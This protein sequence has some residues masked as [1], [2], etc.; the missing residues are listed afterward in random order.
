MQVHQ[1]RN[2]RLMIKEKPLGYMGF[3]LT[4]SQYIYGF[5]KS[6][7]FPTFCSL[8]PW[9]VMTFSG[10]PYGGAVKQPRQRWAREEHGNTAEKW[11]HLWTQN[12]R[13]ESTMDFTGFTSRMESLTNHLQH[14]ATLPSNIHKCIVHICRHST[15]TNKLHTIYTK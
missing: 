9:C 10:V 3:Q 2:G 4:A 13:F 6:I 15:V 11:I 14:F 12:Q 8:R 7:F 5:N 1:E